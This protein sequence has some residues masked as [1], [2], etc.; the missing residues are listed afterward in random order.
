MKKNRIQHSLCL[1]LLLLSSCKTVVKTYQ[2]P[3]LAAVDSLYRGAPLAP[4]DTASIASLSWR[5]IFKDTLLQ[6]LIQKGMDNNRNVQ[7]AYS[8]IVQ[9]Q[10]VLTQ[11]KLAYYPDLTGNASVD[12]AKT[13]NNSGTRTN[14]HQYQ[15][16]VSSSW[17]ADIWGKLRNAQEANLSALLS[18]DA[19][20]KAVQTALVA[21]VANAYYAL[22]A[23]DWQLN[24]T[25]QTVAT[26]QKTVAVMKEL[27]KGD[28]VTG[29]AVV[30]SEASMYAAQVSIPDIERN[31]RETENNICYLLGIHSQSIVRDSLRYAQID[32]SLLTGIPSQLLSQRPDVQAAEFNFRQAYAL[33]NVSR[34]KFYPSLV[35]TANGGLGNSSLGSFFSTGSLVGGI[36]AGLT[37][38]ILNKGVNKANLIVAEEQQKQAALNFENTFLQAGR[39]VSNAM[40]A[41]QMALAKQEPR[42]KQLQQLDKSVDYTQQLVRNGFANYSEVLIAMQNLLSAQLNQVNDYLQKIQAVVNLYAALGGGWK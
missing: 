8:K 1:L 15:L 37:Q 35:L 36:L 6:Q 23:Y 38:P 40:Y 21:S 3:H 25:E 24:I 4:L 34:T 32:S 27:K 9:A 31:I 26:W 16:G 14:V 12:I 30:Q 28:V 10:A 18:T 41:Y 22:M 2:P 7:I 29:A 11:S 19:N 42:K 20:A 33:T 13:I 39:E 5:E 17:E